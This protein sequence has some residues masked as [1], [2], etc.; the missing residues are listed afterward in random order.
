MQVG[1]YPLNR[2]PPWVGALANLGLC[3]LLGQKEVDPLTPASFLD[4]RLRSAGES[5]QKGP[6]AAQRVGLSMRVLGHSWESREPQETGHLLDIECCSQPGS[7]SCL[8]YIPLV[9]GG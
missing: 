9:V 8:A 3:L 6:W 7:A 5:W 2:L 4:T 1:G